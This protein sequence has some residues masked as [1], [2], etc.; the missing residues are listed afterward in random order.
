M[1]STTNPIIP[2]ETLSRSPSP[3]LSN[4]LTNDDKDGNSYNG[5][6]LRRIKSSNTSTS[7]VDES[8]DD[9]FDPDED[10]SYTVNRNTLDAI[11]DDI[12]KGRLEIP[13]TPPSVSD[14]GIIHKTLW[15][16]YFQTLS[17]KYTSQSNV[18]PPLFIP[19]LDTLKVIFI[20]P[21]RCSNCPCCD[22]DPDE[23]PDLEIHNVTSKAL[24]EGVGNYLYS[25]ESD[26]SSTEKKLGYGGNFVITGFN[27]MIGDNYLFYKVLY[28]ALEGTTAEERRQSQHNVEQ[29]NIVSG[30][31]VVNG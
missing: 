16:T 7:S 8:E 19:P 26:T 20:T 31:Q 10:S 24:I 11:S 13:I 15:R 9:D 23:I 6:D 5:A 30:E 27:W 22:R 21:E 12:E 4:D 3:I 25:E 29:E 28:I 1:S 18:H 2:G 17:H 14:S